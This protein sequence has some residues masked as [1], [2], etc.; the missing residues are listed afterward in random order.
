MLDPSAVPDK[1]SLQGMR[2]GGMSQEEIQAKLRKIQ[3][4]LGKK[5]GDGDGH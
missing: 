1:E 5:Q 2:G 3:E 4:Q